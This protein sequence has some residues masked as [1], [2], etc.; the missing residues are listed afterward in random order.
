[1]WIIMPLIYF[2]SWRSCRRFGQAFSETASWV[3]GYMAATGILLL[4]HFGGVGMISATPDD[5]LQIVAI[6]GGFI[7]MAASRYFWKRRGGH[8]EPSRNPL[9]DNR[10]YRGVRA[11]VRASVSGGKSAPAKRSRS[12]APTARP[13]TPSNTTTTTTT[14]RSQA[15]S[16]PS[17]AARKSSAQKWGRVVGA[18][19]TP[20]DSRRKPPQ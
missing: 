2:M 17:T 6:V 4:L 15:A 13:A 1:M 11:A 20:S 3:L 12:S 5:P 14:T 10:W 9:T 18:M 8:L 16:R 19:M 7:G